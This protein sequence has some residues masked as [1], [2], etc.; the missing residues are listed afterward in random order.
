M[1]S[2]VTATISTVLSALR[3]GEGEWARTDLPARRRLLEQIHSNAAQHAQEWV[4]TAARIKQLSSDSPLLGE[5]WASGPYSLLTGVHAL[6]ESL[7]ALEKGRSPVDGYPMRSAPG[8][9]TAV[10]VFPHG[11]FDALLLNGFRAEVWSRPGVDADTVRARAGLG[12]RTPASTGGIGVVLGAG[13]IFSI[14]PLDALYQLVADNRVVALKLNPITDPLLPV[15]EKIFAPAIERG[16]VRLLTGGAEVGAALV[17]HPA[18]TAVHMTGSAATHDAIVFGTGAEA[19][20]NKAAGT[21][22]LTKPI[23]SELG[24]VSPT[25]VVPGRWSTA[26]LRFQAEHLATQRLHNNGYNCVAAQVAVISADWPLKQRFLAELRAAIARAPQRPGYYPGSSDRVEAA[27]RSYPQAQVIGA[28]TLIEGLAPSRHEPALHTEYF[29]P[30]LGVLELPGGDPADFLARAVRVCNE[31]FEGTLGA[32]LI[33]HPAT[34]KELGDRFDVAVTELRYGTIA[35]NAWTG[36]GY[37]TARA[38]WGAFPGHTLAD[39]QSGIGVVHNG[40]LIAEPERTVV[41]GPFRP[42]PRSLLHGEFSLSPKPPWFVTNRT[43]ATT[44]QRLTEFAKKPRAAAL[45]PIFASALR[46]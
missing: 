31:E 23:T 36:L 16:F 25:I 26:D 18:V 11:G 3:R 35:V 44:L 5:E 13:N 28:R 17:H 10:E 43:G 15:L 45:P 9:R 2:T 19:A 39:I 1:T 27:R 22:R 4:E 42:A 12:Q 8:G 29:A 41:R 40:L 34:I 6:T 24:G 20:R 37:L 32:N 7:L 14:A 38:S 30:V 21:P 33:A 46:G